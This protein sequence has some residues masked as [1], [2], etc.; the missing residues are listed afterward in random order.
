MTELDDMWQCLYAWDIEV[1]P[2][3]FL[4]GLRHMSSGTRWI[5]EVSDR[6][7]QQHQF[8]EMVYRLADAQT[9]GIGYNNEG[10]DYPV[11]HFILEQI[12]AKGS[13]TPFEI[14]QKSSA[15]IEAP[16]GDWTHSVAPWERIWSQIDL[17]KIM[18]F[19]NVNRR[20]SLKQLEIAMRCAHVVDLPFPPGTVLSSEQIDVLLWYMAVHDVP[21]T[22]RFA[23]ECEDEIK[24]RFDVRNTMGPR[25]VNYNDTRIG[26]QTFVDELEKAGVSCYEKSN[27]KKYPRQTPRPAGIK[28]AD[29]LLP[30]QFE[31]EPFNEIYRHFLNATIPQ[32]E[33]KG[34]FTDLKV[35]FNDVEFVYGNGGLHASVN[36]WKFKETDTHEIIDID[37]EGYY[38]SLSIANRWYPEHLGE[39]FCDINAELKGRRGLFKKGTAENKAL[40]L[41]GNGVYGKSN[42]KHSPFFDPQYTM[43]ITINGQ[44]LLTWLAEQLAKIDGVK[45]IQANTDG[46][47]LF[48]ERT[49]REEI[50]TL[51]RAWE[52][53]TR[54]K[55][56]DANYRMMAIRDV[57]NYIAVDQNGKVKEKNAYLTAQPGDRNPTGWHQDLSSLVIPKAAQAALIHGTDPM[58]F[59]WDHTDPFDFMRRLKVQKTSRV[60]LGGVDQQKI[61]RYYIGLRGDQLV[62]VM[63]PERHK[64]KTEDRYFDIDKGWNAAMCNDA[65]DFD[66]DNLNRRFY[67]YEADKLINCIS[68]WN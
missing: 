29:V 62:K 27:G 47:T 32:A 48:A 49:K 1:Y 28:V 18:H 11:I 66:W 44:L 55:L 19:D 10:Y 3:V 40:K 8:A 59:I 50:M 5:Y 61:C 2:N 9:E 35:D 34:F 53:T 30:F 33:T 56:E 63:P 45:L 16:F 46:V 17:Y 57:N 52:A 41:A 64:G 7:D 26:Q 6:R 54:L 4:A 51:C 22:A 14:Y 12:S 39:V 67:L 25:A 20:S 21:N 36:G 23:F 42:D 65:T 58:K 31:H 37:V 13:V 38:P 68:D 43:A 60:L 15:I 24:F